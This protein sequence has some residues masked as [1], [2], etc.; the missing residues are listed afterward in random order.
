MAAAHLLAAAVEEDLEQVGEL[1]RLADEARVG[2]LAEYRHRH[3]DD[4][5]R[6]ASSPA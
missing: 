2:V 6:H 4:V 5:E 1:D 3:V